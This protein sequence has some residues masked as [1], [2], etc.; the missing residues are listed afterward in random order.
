[1]NFSGYTAAKEAY[2]HYYYNIHY[3]SYIQE[4]YKAAKEAYTHYYYTYITRTPPHGPAPAYL[5]LFCY[6]GLFCY[7]RTVLR[8]L[9]L[10]VGLDTHEQRERVV[11]IIRDSKRTEYHCPDFFFAPPNACI[12]T[13]THTHTH[14]HSIC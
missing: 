10:S 9:D 1:M 3:Y 12:H 2:I 6:I 13:H 14:T 5:G 7:L 8:L 11:V 4:T